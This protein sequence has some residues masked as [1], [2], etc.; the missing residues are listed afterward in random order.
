LHY[1]D[2][3]PLLDVLHRLVDAGNTII[4]IKQNLEVIRTAE[5]TF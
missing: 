3:Q 5:D 4:V 2:I 1:A